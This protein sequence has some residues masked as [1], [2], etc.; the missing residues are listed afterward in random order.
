MILCQFKMLKDTYRT[1]KESGCR[2]DQAKVKLT[3]ESID[4]RKREWNY[5]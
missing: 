1:L 4:Q 2:V 5:C 3:L